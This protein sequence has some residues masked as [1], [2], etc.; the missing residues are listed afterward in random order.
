VAVLNAPLGYTFEQL[1][2]S[3]AGF[4]L[5]KATL[6]QRAVFRVSAGDDVG[7]LWAHGV[8]RDAFGGQRPPKGVIPRVMALTA[9]I[10][11]AKSK[12]A[13]GRVFYGS[14]VVD[15]AKTSPGDEIRI[16]IVS[17]EKDTAGAVF[18]HLVENLEEKPALR[19]VMIGKPTA[20]AVWL[21]HPSGKAIEVKVTALSRYASTLVGRWLAG[22]VFDEAP[23]MVG[24]KDGVRNLEES[25]RAVRGRVLPGGQIM[26][27]GSPWAP[28]GPIYDLV[29]EHFGKPSADVCIVRGKG[30]DMNPEYWTPEQVDYVRRTDPR[31]YRTDCLGE[32]ADSEDAMFASLEVERA[33]RAGPLVLPPVPGFNYCAAMDPATRGNAW[34]L[35]VIGCVGEDES[36]RPKYSVVLARQWKGSKSKPLKATNVLAEAADILR[37]YG[38]D[39][40]VTDQHQVDTLSEI[41]EE[42]GLML[43]E[44][45]FNRE[46]RFE[47]AERVRMMISEE[48]L[49]L[50]PDP[51]V[52]RDLVATVRK[53]TQN[54]VTLEL[55][56]TGDGRHADYVPTLCLGLEHA[57]PPPAALDDSGDEAGRAERAFRAR[58]EKDPA[59]K[60]ALARADARKTSSAFKGACGDLRR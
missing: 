15:L 52:R 1:M 47:M 22:C 38:I 5:E 53:I 18:T 32:F 21:R 31:A 43:I 34:T 54:G 36:G 27:P 9:A 29:D 16:P 28:F 3:A 39:S 24:E 26:L 7:D 23:R 56:N 12:W 6:V 46:N 41:G 60:A 37:P 13:A 2:T 19:E 33:M 40:I 58:A 57:P 10:R 55:P 20:D 50:P 8:V 45:R 4:G 30:P 51:Q 59:F 48:R 35:M 17:T 44:H 49:E 14:Q 11:S 42:L 25:I